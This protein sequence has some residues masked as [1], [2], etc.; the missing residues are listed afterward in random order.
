LVSFSKTKSAVSFANN[1]QQGQQ[2]STQ[3]SLLSLSF[4]SPNPVIGSSTPSN[5]NSDGVA[6]A[7]SVN[8]L[9]GL[10]CIV[11]GMLS[12]LDST[13]SAL[14]VASP[15][16]QVVAIVKESRG[17]GRGRGRPS[18]NPNAKTSHHST[19]TPPV[20]SRDLRAASRAS[21]SQQ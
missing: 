7:A 2:G 18:L 13:G 4:G 8:P 12:E 1:G 5:E 20:S 11:F 15:A 19:P 3:G 14:D 16:D 10:Q 21:Q 6:V 17:R 9:S